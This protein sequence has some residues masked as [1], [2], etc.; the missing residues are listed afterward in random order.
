MT[1]DR[2][3]RDLLPLPHLDFE[4]LLCLSGGDLH[5]Y[6]MGKEIRERTGGLLDP[7]MSSLYLAIRR[8]TRHG[9]VEDAGERE[10]EDGRPA[11]RYYRITPRGRELAA[12]EAQR[13]RTQAKNARRILRGAG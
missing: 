5:G 6:A 1:G 12:L 13:I 3:L 8:L 9:L 7:G 2:P 4:I 10:S 11:R